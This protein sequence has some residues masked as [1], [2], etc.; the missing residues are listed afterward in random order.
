MSTVRKINWGILGCAGIAE[1]A[2]IPAVLESGNGALAAIAARDPDRAG[3]WA[4]RFGFARAHRTYQELVDDPAVEAVYNPLPNDLH[5]EWSIRAMRAGKHVLCE[6]PMAM[7]A[8][9]V[10]DMIRAAETHG[11][12]LMEGFMYKFHPQIARTLELVRTGA[13]GPVR[14]VHSS[15]TFRFERDGTNYRWS[16][17]RG[18]GALYDV[19][20]YAISL[21]RLILDAEPSAATAAA[22]I[23]PATGVDM[24]A[25]VLLE[26]PGGR[27]ALC[28]ASFESHFQSRL[29]AAGR[30]GAHPEGEHVH[31]HGRAFQRGRSR[32]GPAPLSRVRRLAQHARPRRL[33]RVHPDRGAR[34][35]PF[36]RQRTRRLSM[37]SAK[38]ALAIFV[39]ALALVAACSTTYKSKPQM[40]Y[41]SGQKVP[42]LY[43]TVLKASPTEIEFR[44]QVKFV[45]QK[46]YHLVLD[47]NEPVAQGWFSTQRAGGEAYTVKM[48]P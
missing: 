40:N 5:A 22:R 2:F 28:D 15:F 16:P 6:K 9:E 33:L 4:R 20:C 26:F 7:N 3:D 48:K 1:K 39:I 17:A 11:V 23:D 46:M 35:H 47:G 12:L 10:R 43:I 29:V 27:F 13:I 44:I 19:G 31:P 45:T 8:L 34:H 24:T 38:F 37:R 41:Y 14:S 42:D 30:E 32:P 25:A 36:I 21:A 18:G